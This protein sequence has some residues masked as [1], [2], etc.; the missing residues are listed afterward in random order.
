MKARAFKFEEITLFYVNDGFQGFEAR[1]FLV[2]AS[3][4]KITE[5]R[6]KSLWQALWLPCDWKRS[7]FCQLKCNSEMNAS[8][9]VNRWADVKWESTNRRAFVQ[10]ELQINSAW[11]CECTTTVPTSH[12]CE[13]LWNSPRLYWKQRKQTTTQLKKQ[14]KI[15]VLPLLIILNNRL[16]SH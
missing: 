6:L 9:T 16:R 4:C 12:T 3:R 11:L 10:S 5:L 7:V 1:I 2:V 14:G 13:V 15:D 8:E